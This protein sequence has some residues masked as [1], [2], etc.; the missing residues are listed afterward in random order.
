MT[1]EAICRLSP[2]CI[3]APEG[4]SPETHAYSVVHM[5]DNG[6]TETPK[7]NPRKDGVVTLNRI[8][9]DQIIK[10]IFDQLNGQ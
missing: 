9:R 8:G 1:A 4:T 7:A 2:N 5:K 3:P 10:V 6:E